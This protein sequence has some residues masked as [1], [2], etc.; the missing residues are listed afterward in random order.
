MS[1]IPSNLAR[2]P[3]SLTT[4]S[5]L[6]NLTRTSQQL[7]EAQVQLASGLAVGKPSDN[8]IG[9]SLILTLQRGMDIR[10]Q[11]FRNLNQ[12]E[13]FM[14]IAD[15]AL[16]EA[17][18]IVLQSRD[19]ASQMI[20][21][22]GDTETRRN[23]AEVINAMINEMVDLA[24]SQ[25]TS[26]YIF[27][28]SQIGRTPLES[29]LGGYRYTGTKSGLHLDLGIGQ[30]LEVTLPL[31]R[32]FGALSA[33]V[34]GDRDLD[35]ALV[36]ATKIADLNGARGLGVSLSTISIDVGAVGSTQVDLS[37]ADTVQD[38]I[39]LIDDAIAALETSSGTPILGPSRVGIN[40][41]GDGLALDV[42]AGLTVTIGEVGGSTTAADLGLSQS[43]FT[44]AA[45]DGADVDPRLTMLTRVSDLAGVGPLSDFV[46][47]NAG[48]TR[49]V[50]LTGVTTLQDL[51]NAVARTNIGAR[52][53]IA[54]DGQR[55]NLINELSGSRMSVSETVGGTTATE[56]GVRSFTSSTQLSDFNNGLGVEIRSGS[57]DPETGLP[58]PA[59]D[60][61]FRIHLSDGTYFD[62]D[63]AGAETVQDVIDI[64]NAAALPGTFTMTLTDGSNGLTLTDLTGGAGNFVVEQRNGS[65][66]A[67]DL[68]IKVSASGATIA[69]E[70]RAM[71]EVD[72]VITHLI[73]LR[74]ALMN[75]DSR[76]ITF[77]GEALTADV[78]RLAQARAV[79]GQRANRVQAIRSREEDRQLLDRSMVS[80]IQDADYNEVSIR[81]ATLQTQ[82]QAAMIT[83]SQL[84]SLSLIRFLG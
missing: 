59:L 71:I 24:N 16:S 70:D 75:D 62:V 68:G 60:V 74:D 23:S 22:G 6:G 31:D 58:D 36:G 52:L 67:E 44:N 41:T 83:A 33:R 56:L 35:P 57:V 43:A 55:I 7:L 77:A 13:S 18:D 25:F 4:Q 21:L 10:E 1:A 2:V 45:P 8:P 11:R 69:G 49:T 82:L 14:N 38:A 72:S 29:T 19:I 12:A 42:V 54:E 79:L 3:I 48:Q 15:G 27:G 17:T 34:Q 26:N 46:I 37:G 28:G 50:D 64:T 66:A 73:N 9:A 84:G 80:Q 53:E 32:A 78:D 61:D 81:F 65:H 39:D 5:M 47:T 20:G 30:P 63:L 40:S 76:G 51:A